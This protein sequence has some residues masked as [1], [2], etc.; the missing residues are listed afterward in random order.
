MDLPAFFLSP[1]T[2][3]VAGACGVLAWAV[4]HWGLPRL[5]ARSGDLSGRLPE[6]LRANGVVM[7]LCPASGEPHHGVA[8][9]VVVGLRGRRLLCEVVDEGVNLFFNPGDPLTCEFRPLRLA[10]ARVNCFQTTYAGDELA[11]DRVP[12]ILLDPPRDPAFTPRRAQ[13]RK[14]VVDQQFIR[15]QIWFASPDEPEGLRPMDTAPHLAVNVQD[16]RSG[17]DSC[18][19]VL[20]VSTRG[21]G[22]ELNCELAGQRCAPGSAVILNLSLFSFRGKGFRSYWYAGVIRSA[23]ETPRGTLRVGVQFRRAGRETP[24]ERSLTWTPLA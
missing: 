2:W 22:L 3:A 1:W 4:A 12:R 16:V 14:K 9:C 6:Y 5:G 15:A 19:S 10:G 23:E 13:V 11:M 8:R 18:G 21:V 24:G 17:Q 20:N 7:N